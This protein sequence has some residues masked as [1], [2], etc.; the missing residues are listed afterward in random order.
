MHFSIPFFLL[1]L[2]V[3]LAAYG[4]DRLWEYIKN[5]STNIG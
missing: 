1:M 2:I 4:L 5:R 3:A